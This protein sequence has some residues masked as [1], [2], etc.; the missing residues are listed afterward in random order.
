MKLEKDR[1]LQFRMMIVM[2]LLGILTIGFGAIVGV[3]F[4]SL[5]PTVFTV[6]IISMLQFMYGHK[7][8][9]KAFGA[10]VV[11]EE[12]YPELHEQ[13]TRLSQQADMKKPTVAVADTPLANAFAAGRSGST[14][15][16]CVTTEIMKQ[17]NS[18]EL[19]AVIAHELAHIKNRD[20]VVMTAAGTIAAVTGLIMR[21]GFLFSSGNNN[22]GAPIIVAILVSL[23]TYIISLL[24]MRTLSRY[25]EFT[26]DKGAVAITGNP[27]A[28]ASALRKIDSSVSEVPKEDLR[29]AQSVSAFMISP[30]KGKFSGLLSTHPKTEK[31]ISKL[32]EMARNIN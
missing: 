11:T 30:V 9:L 23:I 21:W 31:R 5:I 15:T 14:A 12:E 1:N 7:I 18:E 32:E 10:K 26:A 29:N 6:V 20:M 17:L 25:R 2:V 28:L 4:Q 24:L 19:E 22:N 3:Y 27:I 16:V 13:V 8:A